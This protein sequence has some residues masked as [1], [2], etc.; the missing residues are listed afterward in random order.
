MLIDQPIVFRQHL[1]TPLI[2]GTAIIRFPIHHAVHEA[3]HGSKVNSE[4]YLASIRAQSRC[5][6]HRHAMEIIRIQAIDIDQVQLRVSRLMIQ[7]ADEDI[8][9]EVSEFRIMKAKCHAVQDVLVDHIENIVAIDLETEILVQNVAAEAIVEII[10]TVINTQMHQSSLI[11]VNNGWRCNVSR[12]RN[13]AWELCN[14][15]QLLKAIQHQSLALLIHTIEIEK[16]ESTGNDPIIF[17][18]YNV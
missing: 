15:Q 11:R 1:I 7:E 6:Q 17:L 8:A 3:H 9:Q 18:T 14:K 5:V 12:L 4:V 2:T 16:I 13:L 10:V